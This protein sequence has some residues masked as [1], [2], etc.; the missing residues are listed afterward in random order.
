MK[1]SLHNQNLNE[2]QQIEEFQMLKNLIKFHLDDDE[3]PLDSRAAEDENGIPFE[4]KSCNLQ[5]N[6]SVRD[7]KEIGAFRHES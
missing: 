7:A 6:S 4:P 5:T 1:L 2:S 3:S